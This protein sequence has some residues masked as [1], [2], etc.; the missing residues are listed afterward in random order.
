MMSYYTAPGILKKP[1]FKYRRDY[2]S[3]E[4]LENY[5]SDYFNMPIKDL[6]T[7]SEFKKHRNFQGISFYVICHFGGYTKIEIS[8]KYCISETTIFRRINETAL[9]YPNDLNFIIKDL[10][11]KR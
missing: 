9:E 2:F 4:W 8:K 10:T 6:S 1:V 7:C 5:L 11:S 3:I